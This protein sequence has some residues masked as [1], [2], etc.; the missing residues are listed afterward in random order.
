MD[1]DLSGASGEGAFLCVDMG[2][3]SLQQATAG[4]IAK[5]WKPWRLRGNRR[6]QY[7]FRRACLLATYLSEMRRLA[8]A[9]S[10]V[11]RPKANPP[12]ASSQCPLAR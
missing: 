3:N 1:G 9:D 2:Q 5:K 4:Y 8:W 6:A 11:H 10:P 12:A 7:L